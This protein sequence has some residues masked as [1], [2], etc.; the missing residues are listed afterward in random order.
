M[1]ETGRAWPQDTRRIVDAVEHTSGLF[2]VGYCWRY[3]PSVE[4]MQQVLQSGE[5]GKVL[6][7]R[8]HA[9]CSHD[10]ADTNHMKQPGD[11]GGAFYVIGCHTIDHPAALWQTALGQCADQQVRRADERVSA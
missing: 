8:A 7:V 5:I 2:Q 3:A 10:E 4:K 9:G 11:R 6:Q 1:R